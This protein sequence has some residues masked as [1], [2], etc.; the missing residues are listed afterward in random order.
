MTWDLP[1]DKNDKEGARGQKPRSKEGGA[2]INL[3]RYHSSRPLA[4]DEQ[5]EKNEI[6]TQEDLSSI[7]GCRRIPKGYRDPSEWNH[8]KLIQLSDTVSLARHSIYSREKHPNV[9]LSHLL[10]V[11]KLPFDT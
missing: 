9:I 1:E 8:N 4:A 11:L 5:I 2:W 7:V 3:G 6:R 10:L